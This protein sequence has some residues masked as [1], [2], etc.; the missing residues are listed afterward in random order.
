MTLCYCAQACPLWQHMSADDEYWRRL[1][2]S[3]Y[4]ISPESFNPP[5]EPVKG[6]YRTAARRL[7][8]MIVAMHEKQ[9]HHFI[10]Q[11]PKVPAIEVC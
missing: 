7:R 4:S 1:C 9:R 5:P 11:L 3:K 10:A 2:R 8:Q 6:L